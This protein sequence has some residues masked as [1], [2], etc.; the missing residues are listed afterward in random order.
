VRDEAR[1]EDVVTKV[2]AAAREAG[3][4]EAI[5][6]PVWRQMIDRCIAYEFGVWDRLRSRLSAHQSAGAGT[7]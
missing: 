5:A 2:K 6:E 1:I 4:S 7:G 3:L